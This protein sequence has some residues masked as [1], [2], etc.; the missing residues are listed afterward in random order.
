MLTP[1][2]KWFFANFDDIQLLSENLPFRPNLAAFG[3][4]IYRPQNLE[5]PEEKINIYQ[6]LLDR[7]RNH[8]RELGQDW[9]FTITGLGHL[10]W[11]VNS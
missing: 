8:S 5:F 11:V 4:Y 6:P 1:F 10:D 7:L 3:Y 9:Q 2:Q